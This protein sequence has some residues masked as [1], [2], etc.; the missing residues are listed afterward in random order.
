MES[1]MATEL[2]QQDFGRY[3][4]MQFL[5]LRWGKVIEDRLYEDTY[6][7]ADELQQR[8]SRKETDAVERRPLKK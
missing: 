3:E 6:K 2:C 4:A 5:R 1:P 8:L 7:L